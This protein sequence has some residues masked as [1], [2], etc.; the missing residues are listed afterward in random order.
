ML[1][2]NTELTT[3]NTQLSDAKQQ[4]VQSE[5]LASIGQL[6]AGVAHEIN[7]PIGYVNSNIGSLEKYLEDVF[8]MLS[9]AL[10]DVAK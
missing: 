7:N 10:K 5:K 9:I 2:R 3:L 1:R 6:A 8:E 4:L